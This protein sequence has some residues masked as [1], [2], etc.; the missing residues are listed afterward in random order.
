MYMVGKLLILHA[1]ARVYSKIAYVAVVMCLYTHICIHAYICIHI[2]IY[3][4][5]YI[6]IYMYIYKY[7]YAYIQ[8]YIHIYIYMDIYRYV[9]INTCNVSSSPM[10]HYKCVPYLQMC[11][12]FT[13]V[14]LGRMHCLQVIVISRLL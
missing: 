5:I 12:L 6:Y 10:R 9:Y 7:I 11:P 2:Y 3:A 1:Y 14:S 4:H 13:N 8:I